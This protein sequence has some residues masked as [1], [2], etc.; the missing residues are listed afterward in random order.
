MRFLLLDRI[1]LWEPGARAR[2]IKNVALTE[3]FLDDHFPESPVMPGVLIL[4]GMAQLGG[5]LLQD[6]VRRER[7]AN[8]KAV[9]S[10][11][12]RAKFRAPAFPGDRLEYSVE[13]RSANE[14]AGRVEARAT[15]EGELRAESTLVFAFHPFD[16]ERMERLQEEIVSL[17]MRDIRRGA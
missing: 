5:L 9:L 1:T 4:E 10:L 14:L 2:A 17:W 15:C 3:D 13:L 11:V 6:A 16:D 12:E 7:G 8:V